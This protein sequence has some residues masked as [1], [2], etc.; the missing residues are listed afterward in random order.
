M[1]PHFYLIMIH[2]KQLTFFTE[3]SKKKKKKK[4]YVR[5]KIMEIGKK[6]EGA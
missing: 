5:K 4:S 6:Y 2:L 3:N 1:N